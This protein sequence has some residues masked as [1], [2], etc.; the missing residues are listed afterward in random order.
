MK[1][2]PKAFRGIV[3]MNVFFD[4]SDPA[5]VCELA[6]EGWRCTRHVGHDGPCAA[7]PQWQDHCRVAGD[8]GH[9]PIHISGD[10]S[11]CIHCGEEIT[12]KG[13]SDQMGMWLP[14][15]PY[16]IEEEPW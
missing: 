7:V 15:D 12:W 14:I 4:E 13:H 5:T 6:P 8:A 1:F 3:A 11:H 2:K 9:E 16:V 10:Y